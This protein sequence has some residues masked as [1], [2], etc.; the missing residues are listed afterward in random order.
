MCCF[1]KIN[2]YFCNENKILNE[3]IL[4]IF[5]FITFILVNKGGDLCILNCYLINGLTT[6]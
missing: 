3:T 4:R 5:Y 1:L 2:Y 6:Y